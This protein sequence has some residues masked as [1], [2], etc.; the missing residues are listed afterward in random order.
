VS[1]F[2]LD[3]DLKQ[4]LKKSKW[5]IDSYK[6]AVD[7]Y[8]N[9]KN[10]EEKREMERLIL[11]IKQSFS[12]EIRMNDPIK[13]RL[14]KIVSELYHRF[15]GTFLFEP[16]V[17]YGKNGI[18]L[19]KKHKTEKEK[20]EK[21]IDELNKKVEEIKA[22]KVY[23]NSFEWRFEFPEVLNDDGDFIGFDVVIGNPP[24]IFGGNE[25]ISDID[26][27]YY[28]AN[29]ETG[30]GKINLFALFIEKAYNILNNSSQFGFI[31]P[32]T[33]LRVTSYDLSRRYLVNNSKINS[34]YDFGDKVF[35]DAVTTA[36]VI[37]ATKGV[38]DNFK[39][40]IING[41]KI[42]VLN[43]QDI[44]DNEYVIAINLDLESHK[45]V[46]KLKENILLGSI[47]QEMIF[48]VVITKNKDEVVSKIEKDDWKPFLEGKEIGSYFIK[49][50]KQWLN[51]NTKLLHRARTKEIF[52]SPEKILI[53]RITGGKKPLKA[54]YDNKR[55][56][57]KES[58]N[59][60]IINKDSPVKTKYILA[61]LNSD[62]INWFYS[63]QFTNNSNL[64][65][66]LS[67]TYLSQIPIAIPNES[68]E[69]RIIS[70]VD[71]ILSIKSKNHQTD[72]TDLEAQIDQLVYQLYDLTEEEIA[73]VESSS[74]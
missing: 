27:K 72:T 10:K 28:K 36:I 45:L 43:K 15:T 20:L 44:I 51:Y 32:N 29:F 2:A 21:E 46:G 66:N 70:I 73:I 7:T 52:E 56:Y 40:K 55:F 3:A 42:G 26:K 41:S 25:G 17:P 49:E 19:E 9:A 74:K 34:I 16:Q 71:E 35:D 61:L 13:K 6:L 4:A 12:S 5:T 39:I 48:G 11:E 65:V 67:K 38:Y 68:D 59:N 14:D 30:S 1:R 63:I 57:N 23:E 24:Y 50:V 18:D 62:L 8:R 53:Q 60:I 37:T 54:A 33:F 64:T 47:C 58:I 69:I 22:N 31:I